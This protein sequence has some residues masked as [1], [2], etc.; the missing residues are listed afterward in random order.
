MGRTVRVRGAMVGGSWSPVAA[1]DAGTVG[2]SRR[3]RTDRSL[4]F[5]WA[6]AQLDETY[7]R[8]PVT[9]TAAVVCSAA[10]ARRTAPFRRRR[11]GTVPAVHGTGAPPRGDPLHSGVAI[12]RVVDPHAGSQVG[13]GH[14]WPPRRRP[15]APELTRRGCKRETRETRGTKTSDDQ[16][17]RRRAEGADRGIP[18]RRATLR[19]QHGGIGAPCHGANELA[20]LCAS[21]AAS[22]S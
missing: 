4:R 8:G 11:T 10:V 22:T 5:R 2:R 7:K 12:G 20:Q 6:H 13:F 9:R 19:E 1:P 16:Q 3:R 14:R 15:E 17:K 18:P 21:S